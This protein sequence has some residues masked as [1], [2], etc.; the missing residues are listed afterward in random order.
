MFTKRN[1]RWY[2]ILF[3]F[4]LVLSEL[5]Q[6]V[7]VTAASSEK[8][9]P[10]LSSADIVARAREWV[11]AGVI[12]S[13]SV[14]ASDRFQNY[15]ADCS[16][17]VSMAWGIPATAPNYGLNTTTLSLVADPLGKALDEKTGKPIMA[18]MNM[19]HE[20]DILLNQGADAHVI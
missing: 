8:N 12:Y 9:I 19:L 17:L 1:G 7:S 18:T 10:R 3:V 16:G 15:R 14:A 6:S 20:G 13:Q 11:T 2:L 5:L 4:L